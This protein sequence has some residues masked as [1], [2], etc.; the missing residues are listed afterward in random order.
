[1]PGSTFLDPSQIDVAVDLGGVVSLAG[2]VVLDQS[3]SFEHGDLG[4]GGLGVDHH[5]IAADGPAL[6]LTA[7]AAFKRL[8]VHLDRLIDQHGLNRPAVGTRA[9]P[10]TTPPAAGRTLARQEYPPRRL[11]HRRPAP[12]PAPGGAGPIRGAGRASPILGFGGVAGPLAAPLAPGPA[13][14]AT[15]APGLGRPL[16]RPAAP[17]GRDARRDR[18]WRA[19][20]AHRLHAAAGTGCGGPPAPTP[21]RLRPLPPP[22]ARSR[23]PPVRRSP[24]RLPA[25]GAR[26]P[27]TGRS[28]P[29]RLSVVGRVAGRSCDSGSGPPGSPPATPGRLAFRRRLPGRRRLPARRATAARRRLPARRRLARR[30]SVSSGGTGAFAIVPRRPLGRRAGPDGDG[31]PAGSSRS[32][33]GYERV[34]PPGLRLRG[35]RG[36]GLGRARH[37]RA[38]RS[39][40]GHLGFPFS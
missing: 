22:P 18:A 13:E 24:R 20:P 5:Q 19:R 27:P 17:P 3:P 2:N 1:M 11:H 29:D 6:A 4:G 33:A 40:V 21:R 8:I 14:A 28:V 15:P 26:R 25:P 34:R 23:G 39:R 32:R 10:A 12:V 31:V 36:G 35:T 16:A 7:A 37:I 9:A 30:R 38:G